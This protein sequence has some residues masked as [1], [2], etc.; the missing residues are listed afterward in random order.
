MGCRGETQRR[1]QLRGAG[2]IVRESG[3]ADW[4]EALR[5]AGIPTAPIGEA[6]PA[7]RA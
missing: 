3:F 1:W 5:A 6:R 4:D 2:L 7:T